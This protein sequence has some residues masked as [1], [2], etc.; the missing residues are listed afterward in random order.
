MYYLRIKGSKIHQTDPNKKK[1]DVAKC[2]F[3]KALNATR[4]FFYTNKPKKTTQR[5]CEPFS[6]Q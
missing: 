5:S 6:M 3:E 1:A 4:G 2:Y